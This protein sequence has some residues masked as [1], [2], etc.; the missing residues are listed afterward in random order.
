MKKK[1]KIIFVYNADSGMFN[2]LADTA[3]KL[4]S[5]STYKCNLCRLTYGQ[6]H[7]KKEWADFISSFPYDIKFLHKN[8]LVN[9]YPNIRRKLP[10]VFNVSKGN[11]KLLISAKEIDKSRNLEELKRLVVQKLKTLK[12]KGK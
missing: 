3:H 2:S 8:E 7:E 5:P 6:L 11:L 4:L 9:K 10:A 12:K 1:N